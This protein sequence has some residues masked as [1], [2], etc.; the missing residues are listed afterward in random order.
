MRRR[1][2]YTYRE[3]SMWSVNGH[4]QLQN[5]DRYGGRCGNRRILEVL[6]GLEEQRPL[7]FE[8]RV[9]FCRRWSG[10]T[11]TYTILLIYV[12]VCYATSLIRDGTDPAL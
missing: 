12:P 10:Q 4:A 3:R 1:L 2:I 6:R 5:E 11:G 8:A 7:G 9:L